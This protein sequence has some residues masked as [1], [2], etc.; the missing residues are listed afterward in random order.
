MSTQSIET[1]K[2]IWTIDKIVLSYLIS[3]IG[4]YT[5]L[6]LLERTSSKKKL[7]SLIFIL[8][9]GIILGGVGIWSMHFM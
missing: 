6:Q 9:G 2:S 1:L 3:V 8:L 4:S 7:N 5:S